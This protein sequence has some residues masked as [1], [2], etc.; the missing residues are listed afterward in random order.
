MTI[1]TKIMKTN[2]F[3][4]EGWVYLPTSIPGILLSILVI[5]FCVITFIGVDRNSH[6]ASDTLYGIFPYYVAIFVVFFWIAKNTSLHVE[7]KK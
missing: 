1:K 6:S 3:K 5:A 4:K 2:W 7:S